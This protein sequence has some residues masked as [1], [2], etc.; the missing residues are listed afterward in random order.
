MS[1][2]VASLEGEG[3]SIPE[4][5]VPPTKRKKS[6]QP[7]PDFT[8]TCTQVWRR[9]LDQNINTLVVGKMFADQAEADVILGT[10]TGNIIVINSNKK[11]VVLDTKADAIQTLLLHDVTRLGGSEL[12]AGDSQ[13]TIIT[14]CREQILSKQSFGSSVKCLE[15]YFDAL[16]GFEVVSGDMTGVITAFLPHW[17]L[18]RTS[19]YDETFK[20]PRAYL[21]DTDDPA[22]R[23]LL[24]VILP[25]AHGVDTHFILACDGSPYVHFLQKGTLTKSLELPCLINCMCYGYFVESTSPQKPHQVAL[26]GN[27]GNVYILEDFKVRKLMNIDHPVTNVKR[28]KMEGTT[29]VLLCTGHM[30]G[31]QLYKDGRL[32]HQIETDDWIHGVGIGDIDKDG[33]DEIAFSLLNNEVLVYKYR[34]SVGPVHMFEA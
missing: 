3:A 10:D 31:A 20:L 7:E 9:W 27:D 29:D 8:F 28:L 16:N 22:I 19:L 34:H 1:S 15:V 21:N 4:D 6:D 12:L 23:C 18:W 14:F 26:G 11:D 25:D 17:R 13:G 33:A 5:P 30:N 32:I 24:S 2:S